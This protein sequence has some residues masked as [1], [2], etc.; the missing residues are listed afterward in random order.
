MPGVPAIGL[1]LNPDQDG[2]L[3]ALIKNDGIKLRMKPRVR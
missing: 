3:G 2:F 1:I